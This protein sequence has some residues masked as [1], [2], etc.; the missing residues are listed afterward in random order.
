M[1]RL[2]AMEC[3]PRSC[4]NRHHSSTVGF[5]RGILDSAARSSSQPFW[6]RRFP[7]RIFFSLRGFLG[8]RGESLHFLGP[9]GRDASLSGHSQR[10]SR[11]ALDT[12]AD[13]SRHHVRMDQLAPDPNEPWARRWIGRLFHGCKP[14]HDRCDRGLPG[15]RVSQAK[16]TCVMRWTLVESSSIASTLLHDPLPLFVARSFVRSGSL[17]HCAFMACDLDA[18]ACRPMCCDKPPDRQTAVTPV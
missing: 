8:A 13:R 10:K 17:V 6:P 3:S 7:G 15:S 14:G 9:E 5:H 12:A 4:R 2:E 1:G 18:S 16:M 11:R